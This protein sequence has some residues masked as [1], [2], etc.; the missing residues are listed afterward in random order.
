MSPAESDALLFQLDPSV[1]TW[2]YYMRQA[3][4]GG[5][6]Q[7]SSGPG[8]Q[9]L[10]NKL[11]RL[12]ASGEP[13]A[14]SY[15]AYHVSRFSFF[16]TQAAAGLVAHHAAETLGSS[17]LPNSPPILFTPEKPG[18]A[19]TPLQRLGANAS[20][21]LAMR[22]AECV[23][24]W[25]QDLAYIQSGAYRMP[26]DMLTPN[27][28]YNP[29]FIARRTL[30]FMAE[31]TATLQRRLRDAK[32]P[33]WLQSKLYPQ[34]FTSTFHHQT[35]GWFSDR[36]ADI[37]EH[38]TEVLFVGRQDAMQRSALP[39]ISAYV[40]ASPTPP[41]QMRLLEVAA[42]TGRFHTFIKDNWPEMRSVC[43]D[44]SPFYLAR[45]RRNLQ[46][47]K[48]LRQPGKALGGVD[49]TGVEFMQMAAE[50]LDVPDASFDIVVCVYLFHELPE[51][52]RRKAVAEMFRVL[53]PGGLCVLTDSTQ[54]GDRPEW[55]NLVAN[56]GKFDEPWYV[57]FINHKLGETFKA[58]GFQ[59]HIKYVSSATKTLSF[60]KP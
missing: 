19:G 36:S 47:W 26:W 52:V 3:G 38:S 40:A 29:L 37:Y 49:D 55:D 56:F 8:I 51:A 11:A 30:G 50:K 18:S 27:K 20:A 28:Q 43:S 14:A 12:A 46:E 59:P 33:V 22:L 32:E 24:C 17:F 9:E 4:S 60:L 53:K 39:P 23:G 21:E 42:G 13:Q 15:W 10:L 6:P 41:S 44:L 25:E 34:Y 54:L 31:A 57:S 35:D 7:Q 1:A 16:V 2:R 5:A 48:A 45:A 58:A